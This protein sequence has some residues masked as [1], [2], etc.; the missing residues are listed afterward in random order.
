[1]L[2]ISI[3]RLVGGKNGGSTSV[4]GS[5]QEENE[6]REGQLMRDLM[7]G[8]LRQEMIKLSQRLRLRFPAVSNRF[9]QSL[10]SN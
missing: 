8:I 1:M 5:L 6:E 3:Y 7:A 10:M 9:Q 2:L 4:T